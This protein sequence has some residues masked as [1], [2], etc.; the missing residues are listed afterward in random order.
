MSFNGDEMKGGQM[1]W[2]PGT[3]QLQR[4]YWATA[5][6]VC[7]GKCKPQERTDEHKGCY[8]TQRRPVFIPTQRSAALWD[9][10]QWRWPDSGIV[11][12]LTL[13]LHFKKY[14]PAYFYRIVFSYFQLYSKLIT[15]SLGFL[16]EHECQHQSHIRGEDWL[17][18]PVQWWI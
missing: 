1:L 14:H 13:V 18:S 4:N 9:P 17:S 7:V 16:A 3:A 6:C 12:Q 8:L 11:R 15:I 10:L 2:T 5:A